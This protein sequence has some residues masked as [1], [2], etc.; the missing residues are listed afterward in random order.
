VAAVP[1][2]CYTKRNAQA[3]HLSR[4]T[5]EYLHVCDAFIVNS[6]S[7]YGWLRHFGMKDTVSQ[8]Q[9]KNIRGVPNEALVINVSNFFHCGRMN[10]Y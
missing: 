8:G 1:R 6:L 9:V 7:F 2:D 10:A 4:V 3:K 5:N